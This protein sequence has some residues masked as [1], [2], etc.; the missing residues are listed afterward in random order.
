MLRISLENADGVI[1]DFRVYSGRVEEN[2]KKEVKKSTM[3]V[4]RGAKK[5]LISNKSVDT[6]RLLGSI[7][8]KIDNFQGTSGTNVEYARGVEEGTS[9]HIIKPK[10]KKALFWEGASHPV[11]FVRHPGT[12]GKPFLQPSFEDEIPNFLDNLRRVLEV[13]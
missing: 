13:D 2:V 1:E 4:T 7:T 5:N 8:S 11:R 12:R 6:G 9:A 3:K 10:N